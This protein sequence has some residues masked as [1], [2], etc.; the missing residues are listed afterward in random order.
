MQTLHQIPPRRSDLVIILK[1]E[2][3]CRLVDFT[4][5]VDKSLKIKENEKIQKYLDLVREFKNVR[6]MRL[7]VIPIIIDSL[8]TILIGLVRGLE[9]LEIG[10]R[11]ETIE[12]TELLGSVRIP[13][14]V[15]DS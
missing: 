13:R 10:G 6:N 4:V 1:K 9:N 12:T 15:L 14:R 5:P 8:G 11:A 7:T 3:T 2:R